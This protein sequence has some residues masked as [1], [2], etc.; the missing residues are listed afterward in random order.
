MVVTGPTELCPSGTFGGL[1]ATQISISHVS[2]EEAHALVGEFND[3]P[4][5]NFTDPAGTWNC[6]VVGLTDQLVSCRRY[7][8]TS[9]IG[10][11]SFKTPDASWGP[12]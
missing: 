11:V 3:N 10:G 8:G 9:L 12:G 2:C 1:Y 4:N 5:N 6:D 7:S